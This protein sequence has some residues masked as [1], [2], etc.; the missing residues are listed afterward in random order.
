MAGS[1]TEIFNNALFFMGHTRKVNTPTED[2]PEAANCRFIYDTHRRAL[3][4]LAKWSFAKTILTLAPTGNKVTG[5]AYE[6]T[7]PTDCLKALEIAKSNK[8][9][10]DI[11]FQ[12]GSTIDYN[13]G[14]QKR[15]IWTNQEAAQLVFMRDVTVTGFFTPMFDQALAYRMSVDLGRVMA[16]RESTAKEMWSLFLWSLAEAIR[17]GEAE[18]MDEPMPDAPWIQ[19]YTE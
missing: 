11:P 16:T 9:D 14:V 3:L 2:T 1:K 15:V 5:W 19:G 13:T 17:Q 12:A 8:N 10:P 18:A 7:Y 6:Y 4:T